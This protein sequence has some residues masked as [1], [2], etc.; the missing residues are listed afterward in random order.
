MF[1]VVKESVYRHEVITCTA[2]MK[3]AML[4]AEEAI[5]QEDDDHHSMVVLFVGF[6][7]L[8][9]NNNVGRNVHDHTRWKEQVVAELCRHDDRYTGGVRL[10]WREPNQKEQIDQNRVAERLKFFYPD[11]MVALAY[12][13]LAGDPVALDAAA[14]ILAARR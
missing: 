12:D 6:N 10:F 2:S 3:Q 8:P 7:S 4:L 11:P 14:D 13:I 5:G 1:V 9:D